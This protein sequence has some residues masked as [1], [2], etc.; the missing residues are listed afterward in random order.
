MKTRT[1]SDKLKL[2]F[3][4]L[5]FTLAI[6]YSFSVISFILFAERYSSSVTKKNIEI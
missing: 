1:R 6:F 3:K 4:Y 2:I 5:F